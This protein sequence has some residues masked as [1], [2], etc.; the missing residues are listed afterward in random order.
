[1]VQQR[2]AASLGGVYFTATGSCGER[3]LKPQLTAIGRRQ[4]TV[5]AGIE[6]PAFVQLQSPR[7]ALELPRSGTLDAG[8]A[9]TANSDAVHGLWHRYGRGEPAFC[10]TRPA[11]KL[12]AARAWSLN[13]ADR[14][15][16]EQPPLASYDDLT[17][18]CVREV[19]VAIERI[20]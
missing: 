17:G 2:G 13:L 4:V 8:A 18:G 1:M 14:Y 10:R 6:L 11:I 20:A 16:I 15:F 5:V 19:A 12:S 7:S 3:L 9:R